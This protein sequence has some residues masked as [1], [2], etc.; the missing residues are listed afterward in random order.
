MCANGRINHK[1]DTLGGINLTVRITAPMPEVI[2]VQTFH[3]MGVVDR[4]PKFELEL[5]NAEEL[6]AEETENLL[7]VRSG[8]LSLVIDKENWSMRYERD[9]ELLTKSG[10]RDLSYLKT[11]WKGFAYDKGSEDAY[12]RQ[13]LGL[14]VDELVYGLGERFTPFVKNGQSVEIW[15]EDGGTSTEQSYKNIPFI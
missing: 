10:W 15:N 11:D 3:H 7:T 12:M 4:G 5:S 14:S 8:H 13:Q 6:E 1:G 2:R 9:G